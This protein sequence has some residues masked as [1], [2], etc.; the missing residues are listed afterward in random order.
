MAQC[1]LLHRITI[2]RTAF[3]GKDLMTRKQMAASIILLAVCFVAV[4]ATAQTNFK[5]KQILKTGDDAPVPNLLS[6]VEQVSFNSQGQVAFIGDGGLFLKTGSTLKLLAAPGDAAPD[7]GIF[8]Q[9]SSP[10]INS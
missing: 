9:I 6:F 1:R 10:S 5:L 8:L 2:S 7:G 4:S 3:R